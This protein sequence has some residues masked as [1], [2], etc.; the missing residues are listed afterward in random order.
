MGQFHHCP[1]VGFR[2]AFAVS[3]SCDG[4]KVPSTDPALQQNA[5]LLIVRK[6]SNCGGTVSPID[7]KGRLLEEALPSA[8]IQAGVLAIVVLLNASE[9]RYDALR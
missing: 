3:L 7:F 6:P 2:S 4:E 5:A 1:L 8:S 9:G